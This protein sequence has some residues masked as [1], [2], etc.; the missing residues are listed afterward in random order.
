MEIKPSKGIRVLVNAERFE[1]APPVP[2][3][4]LVATESIRG[5]VRREP[6]AGGSADAGLVASRDLVGKNEIDVRPASGSDC[7]VALESNGGPWQDLPCHVAYDLEG[8][9]YEP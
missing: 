4:S 7:D 3:C 6:T 9:L 8:R 5:S 1:R 2:P